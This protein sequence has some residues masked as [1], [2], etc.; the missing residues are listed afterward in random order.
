LKIILHLMH[1]FVSLFILESGFK[2][3]SIKTRC[4]WSDGYGN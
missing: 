2:I 1:I 3:K 4:D